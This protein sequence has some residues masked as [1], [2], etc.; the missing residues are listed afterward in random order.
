MA[1]EIPASHLDLVEQP[2]FVVLSTVMRNGQPQ[3]TPVWCDFDGTHV[4]V[5]TMAQ[6]Q[7]AKNMK[8]NPRVTVLAYELGRPLRYLEI[9]G[10]VVEVTEDGAAE[11]LDKLTFEYT[12]VSTFFGGAAPLEMK[13]K[14]TPTIFRIEPTRVRAEG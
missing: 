1:A 3:S 2:V 10:T 8:A 4:L 14:L 13:D 9:R 11:H 7:K 6:F 5:N 12:G